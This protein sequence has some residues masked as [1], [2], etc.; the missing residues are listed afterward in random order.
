MRER[1]I[2]IEIDEKGNSSIDL[3]GFQGK[4]CAIVAGSFHGSDHVVSDRAKRELNI[5]Q[6]D[7]AHSLLSRSRLK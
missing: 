1:T 6:R 3:N 4:G 5:E 2:T 7:L